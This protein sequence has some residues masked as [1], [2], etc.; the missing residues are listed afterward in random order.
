MAPS[1]AAL[2]GSPSRPR[3]RVIALWIVLALVVVLIAA[4][5]WV[6]IR[7]VLA[8]GELESA[9]PLAS[10]MQAEVVSG[11]GKAAKQTFEQLC[12]H[13]A[14]AARLTSDP[15]WRAFEFI[16]L[17]GPNLTAVRE[18]AAVT[19]DVSQK[20][21]KPLAEIAGAIK[22]SDFKPV[23]GSVGMK[24]LVD[25]QPRIASANAALL[26]AKRE[27]RAIDISG[28]LSPVQGAAKKLAS[29]VD[30]AA[31]SVSEVSRA[32]QLVPAMLGASGPRNYL[33]LFQNPAELRASGGIPG[34]LAL[35]HTENGKI[36]LKQQASGANFPHYKSPVLELPLE[37]RGLYGD[38]TG[39]YIQDVT[40]TPDFPLSAKLA[41]EMWRQQFGVQVDGVLS[42]DPVALGYLLTATGPITL[43]TGDVLT[44]DNAV[45]LL[46][47]DVYARYK[48]P[49]DQ[50]KFFA[51]AAESV[52]SAVS[53]GKADPVALIEALAKAG[54]EH[55]VLAWSAHK[56]NQSLLSGT[57][58][59]G[60][61]PV[62]DTTEQ[63]FGVYFN[64]GTGAKMGTYLDVKV[65]VAQVTC[66]ND[67]RPN[68]GVT[69]TLTNTA[70]ADAA[71]SLPEY[72]TA[73]GSF[74]V[75]PGNIK[76][77]VSVYGAKSMQNLGVDR[78]GTLVG[79]HPTTDSGYPVSAITVELAPGETTTLHFGWLGAKPFKG[80]SLIQ[81][82]P[83]I[84]GAATTKVDFSCES[85]LL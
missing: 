36:E 22:L 57:T 75:T 12:A 69:L 13:S 6:G 50:D 58:L 32:A 1:H 49:A 38:I 2:A 81:M 43:A 53:S 56:E 54:S 20:A 64:D 55:R 73:G 25:A 41:R 59:A 47:S 19:D 62:S 61:L 21:I 80:A 23:N 48:R 33:L 34:A 37:T 4:V 51:A 31:A 14:N 68:Y 60:G 27:V 79:Y 26:E 30:R 16:P 40:L 67:R 77:V 10:K 46:L 11:N 17:L 72:V 71:T 8:K 84:N 35:V 52:F 44:S 9:G 70:P 63:R 74:G 83:T 18:L 15:V 78:D 24:S 82:T 3:R 66:R 29:A 85:P 39:E 7:A 65:G 5:A 76:T 28:T 42:I 45:K